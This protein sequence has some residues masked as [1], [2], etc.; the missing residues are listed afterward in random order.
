MVKREV[1]RVAVRTRPGLPDNW[2][3][4]MDVE[5]GGERVVACPL[6]KHD[7]EYIQ[8][9]SRLESNGGVPGATFHEVSPFDNSPF[10]E[11]GNEWIY[12]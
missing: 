1:E 12:P 10:K 11:V 8:V 7:E 6:Q 3:L 9:L 2:L 4:M 5:D